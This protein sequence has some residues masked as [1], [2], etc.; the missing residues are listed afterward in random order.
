MKKVLVTLFGVCLSVFVWA[1]SSASLSGFVKV[2]GKGEI[3]QY[4]TVVLY[5]N[6]NVYQDA[7]TDENGRFDFSPIDPGFYDLEVSYIGFQT[8]RINKIQINIGKTVKL[9]VELEDEG[10]VKLGAVEVIVYK[11]PLIEMDQTS[12][13]QTL[14]SEQIMNLPLRSIEG[15]AATTAGISSIDGEKAAIRGSRDNATNYYVD[16]VRV[17][18]NMVSTSDIEQMQV[19]TGGLEASYGDVTGGVIS[20]TT[21]GPASKFGGLVELETS[22]GLDAFGY[23]DIRASINGPL[24]KNSKKETILGYRL[25]GQYNIQEEDNPSGIGIYELD[26]SKIK[27]LEAKPLTLFNGTGFT[28]AEFL[29]ADDVKLKKARSNQKSTYQVYTGRLDARVNREIDLALTGAWSAGNNQFLPGSSSSNGLS[30]AQWDLFNHPNN[31][32]DKNRD[33]RVNFR[34]RHRIGAENSKDTTR[35]SS[36]IRNATYILQATYERNSNKRQDLRHE[37]RLFDYGYV[38]KFDYQWIPALGESDNSQAQEGIGHIGFTKTLRAPYTPG[39]INPTLANYN[40]LLTAEQLL[41]DNQ[42][43]AVNSILASTRSSV[44]NIHSNV[45]QVYN[46]FSKSEENILTFNGK[47]TFD[48]FPSGSD[49]TKHSIEFGFVYEQRQGRSYVVA[50]FSLW[51]QASLAANAHFNGVDTNNIVGDTL[52]TIRGNDYRIPIFDKLIV[53]QPGRDFYR[54]IRSRLGI[55]LNQFVNVDG[56]DPSQLSLDMFAAEELAQAQ[57]IGF[58]GYDYLGKRVKAGTDFNSFFRDTTPTGSKTFLVAPNTPIYQA[59]Y[60]QDKFQFKDI[61]FRFGLRVDRFDAN[62]KVMKDPYSLYEITTA[63]DFYAALGTTKPSSL[64]DDAKVYVASENS[65]SVKAFRLGDQWYNAAGST[66]NDGNLIF[67]NQVIYPKYVVAKTEDRSIRSNKFDPDRVFEDYTPQLNWMPRIA[68]SF[69]IADDA[70]FFAHYDVLAQRPPDNSYVSPMDY[71]YFETTGSDDVRN[72][73]NLRSEKT[74]DYEVGFQQKLTNSSALKVSA[75]YKE[76]RDMIQERVLLYTAPISR[77]TTYGNIDFGTVKGFSAA[78]DLRKTENVAVTANYTLQFADGTGSNANSSRGLTSRGNI[79]TLFPLSR[80][81]RHAVKLILDY[82]YS[83]DDYRGPKLFGLD[84]LKNTNINIQAQ[85]ISGRPYSAALRPTQFGGTGFKGIINGSRLPWNFTVDMRIERNILLNK[86][87]IAAGGENTKPLNLVV[88]LRVNNLF[89]TRNVRGVYRY[90]GSPDDDGFLNAPEG[91]GS[92]Q[93]V[94][95]TGTLQQ[96][97]RDLNAFL[98][99]YQWSLLNPSFYSLPRR[100]FLGLTLEF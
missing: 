85:A 19:I 78:F 61:I 4:G 6:N 43:L 53:N 36:S 44:W 49:K 9:D 28:T 14:T 38:G 27:E 52:I 41:L 65:N 54:K 80:D 20:S 30:G 15:L 23:S 96:A 40:N 13:G 70:N 45:G 90:S 12:P 75:F 59:A 25:S 73:A 60:I 8:K 5:K 72:N 34:F 35:K 89:D 3:I 98:A 91:Q 79:R 94:L 51:Q 100:I 83:G 71:Y 62:T 29:H 32:I 99:S 22:K 48:L 97:G 76:M 24:L 7:L 84:L 93:S 39:T 16:G 58:Y 56:L 31:P 87:L 50:P 47:S 11:V 26:E 55:G 95:N 33:W 77:Y 74:I 64:P 68:V 10:G 37:D 17:S 63:K 2:A 18:K 81:E 69:P 1:Q 21:K 82:G 57:V 92:L 86:K 67:G 46:R 88:S 42:Y 66:A